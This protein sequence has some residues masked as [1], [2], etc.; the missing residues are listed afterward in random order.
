[1]NGKYGSDTRRGYTS[2]TQLHSSA[3]DRFPAT[4]RTWN[5]VIDFRIGVDVVSNH[6]PL[7]LLLWLQSITEEAGTEA[8]LRRKQ[9]NRTTSCKW[10]E[11]LERDFMNSVDDNESS[12]WVHRFQ[13]PL[14]RSNIVRAINTVYLTVLS[15]A[16]KHTPSYGRRTKYGR[17]EQWPAFAS[18]RRR[19][20]YNGS[21]FHNIP[22]MDAPRKLAWEVP[23]NF[24]ASLISRLGNVTGFNGMCLRQYKDSVNDM[25]VS[26]WQWDPAKSLPL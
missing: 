16:R 9:T 17:K 23:E 7:S 21:R 20:G 19:K 24:A 5:K 10:R 8:K 14:H 1:M 26:A 4:G 11:N 18:H 25:K 22:F 12:L 15:A 2:V 6:S 3:T 13:S